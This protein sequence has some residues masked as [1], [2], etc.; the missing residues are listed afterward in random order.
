MAKSRENKETEKGYSALAAEYH[1]DR[2][3]AKTGSFYFNEC[4]EMPTTLK[5]L[6][7]VKG[8]KLLDVGS[9]T[10]IYARK[11]CKAGAKVWGVEPSDGMR[12]IA[13]DY[14]PDAV[15]IKGSA[16]DLPHPDAFFHVVLSSLMIDHI[17]ELGPFFVEAKRVLKPKGIL[18]FSAPNPIIET[19]IT[20]KIGGKKTSVLGYTKAPFKDVY[21]DYFTERWLTE[22]WNSM[23]MHHYHRTYG[24]IL[25][26]LTA[27]GFRLLEYQD[28]KPIKRPRDKAYQD[29]YRKFS[30]LPIFFTI[31]AQKEV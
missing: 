6:G 9:G 17:K 13:E 7:D 15:F 2:T 19:R 30:K 3:V 12:A 14:A 10:G 27:S 22:K 29:V 21:G 4:I 8:K 28:A 11:L 20:T 25:N 1:H 23:R 26:T 5:L 31:R 24:T 18:V 16:Y